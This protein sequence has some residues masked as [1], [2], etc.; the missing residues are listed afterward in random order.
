MWRRWS[1]K[2]NNNGLIDRAW[3]KPNNK[4]NN[5]STKCFMLYFRMHWLCFH[6]CVVAAVLLLITVGDENC[7]RLHQNRPSS[8]PLLLLLHTCIIIFLRLCTRSHPFDR[9]MGHMKSII[10]TRRGNGSTGSFSGTFLRGRIYCADFLCA[11]KADFH[12]SIHFDLL[13]QIRPRDF[14]N[15]E[16]MPISGIVDNKTGW[17]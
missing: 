15:S 8:L 10:E 1:F 11:H 17:N 6:R 14:L 2:R 12:H 16:A 4:N 5:K 13:P 3:K 7:E 9:T